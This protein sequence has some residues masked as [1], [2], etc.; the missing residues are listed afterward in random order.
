MPTPQ[1]KRDKQLPR[2][3]T[4][5]LVLIIALIVVR[6][7]VLPFSPPGFYIDEA[8]TGAHVVAMLQHGTDAHGQA[9]P[10]FSS[11]LG[12]GY[13]TPVYLYPLTLW[14]MLFGASETALRY[15]S[16]FVTIASVIILAL[17]VRYWFKN[18][19]ALITAVVGLALPWGWLQG[20]LA[21][22]PVMVPLFVA[23]SFFTF[24][25][26]LFSTSRRAKLIC[27]FIL[28]IS[29]IALAYAYPPARVTAPLLYLTYYAIL[30]YKK[31]ISLRTIILT[32]IGSCIISLPLLLFMLTPEA[33]GRTSSLSVFSHTSIFDGLI[34]FVL[35]LFTL[36]NPKFLF[37]DGDFNMRHSTG[38]QG[39]L[40]LASLL[41]LLALIV[42]ALKHR[43][44]R[45]SPRKNN[46]HLFILIAVAGTLFGL[47]GSALTAEGQPHSLRA[48][49]A[50]PFLA[51]I[52]GLGWYLIFTSRRRALQYTA[53]SFFI[54]CTT[55]YVI[56]FVAF[57]PTRARDSFDVLIRQD[58]QAGN[59]TTYPSMVTDYYA[60]KNLR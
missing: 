44:V 8:A 29:L 21:W 17:G 58:L 38:V 2:L 3:N 11:S 51:A 37:F 53:V 32:I 18:R 42:Y 4:L 22:D 14:A 50:W 60:N 45:F 40:G 57:Y 15:F 48:T 7:V 35:N 33:L 55:L 19:G 13:T 24:S 26:L 28:P 10:L 16:E 59:N 54:V 23:L 1:K 43:H 46:T 39:M 5:L 34:Q 30:V 27:Q 52:I 56:D 9:W 31:T 36:I 47:M 41:A 6:V 49:A 12:G 20:S 25:C